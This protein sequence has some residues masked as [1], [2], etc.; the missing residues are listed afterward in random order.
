MATV[1]GAVLG[2]ALTDS[3]R[4]EDLWGLARGR[5][6]GLGHSLLEKCA[7]V[8]W[9]AWLVGTWG[10]PARKIL[11]FHDGDEEAAEMNQST[12]HA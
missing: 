10:V 6:I 11:Y 4:V 3:N 9:S 5:G 12:F 8:L 2:V 7:A 1:D